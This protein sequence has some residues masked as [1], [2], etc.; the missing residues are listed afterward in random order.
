MSVQEF[1][2][3]DA[4]QST[5]MELHC[6]RN[7]QGKTRVQGPAC[8]VEPAYVGNWAR[9]SKPWVHFKCSLHSSKSVIHHNAGC[10]HVSTKAM[11]SIVQNHCMNFFSLAFPSIR[12]KNAPFSHF[13]AIN[14]QLNISSS[15]SYLWVTAH[16][17]HTNLLHPALWTSQNLPF[18]TIYVT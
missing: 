4:L 17:C 12:K 6:W 13:I 11:P 16:M 10:L 5:W 9:G 14:L 8:F 3:K 15:V 1:S 2:Y 18:V 7:P